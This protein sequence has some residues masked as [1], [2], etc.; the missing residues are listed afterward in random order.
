MI[1]LAGLGT[2]Y[3]V[4][5]SLRSEE[6]TA[7]SERNLVIGMIVTIVIMTSFVMWFLYKR[8]SR[9]QMDAELVEIA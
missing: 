7:K 1:L 8:L 6:A 9:H 5:R 2:I 3:A 4:G